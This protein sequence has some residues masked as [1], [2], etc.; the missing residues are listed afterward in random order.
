MTTVGTIPASGHEPERIDPGVAEVPLAA[1]ADRMSVRGGER[2]AFKVSTG[3][4]GGEIEAR[5]FRSISADPNPDGPGIVEQACDDR[6]APRRFAG[7][8]Q[9][10]IAGS[11]AL[12]DAPLELGDDRIVAI[13]VL[14]WPTLRRDSPQCLVALG[15]FSLALDAEGRFACR[16]GGTSVALPE[17][18]ALR[19]WARLRAVLD[20]GA[21]GVPGSLS[22]SAFPVTGDV[23]DAHVSGLLPA[24]GGSG[25]EVG[26]DGSV[27]PGRDESEDIGSLGGTVLVAASARG[28][29]PADTGIGTGAG[30]RVDADAGR[31]GAR[32]PGEHFNGKLEAPTVLSGTD[33]AS[34][35]VRLRWD[36][37]RATSST[38]VEDTGPDGRHGYL[39][40]LPARAMTGAS[41]D[42]SETCWRHAPAHYGAIHFHE[43]DLVDAR[44]E[45]DFGFDVPIDMPSG[46]YVMR[47][48]QGEHEDAVPFWVCAPL[49]KPT[50]SLCVL[51]S[52][53]TYAVYG[54]HARP[55]WEPDWQERVRDWNAWPHNPA[56]YSA[57]GLSTY[58][59]HAD[60]SGICHASHRRPLFNLRPG[61]LTFSEPGHEGSGLRHFQ[62][63]S[64]LIAWL[65][66]Q[67]IDHDIITDRELHDEGVACLAP[68]RAVTTGTHPEYHTRETLDAL[69]DYRDGGG[70]LAYLGGNG[71]YWRVALHPEDAATIE[72]RRAESGIRAW[73]AEPGEYWQAFDGA[74]G[75]LWRRNGRPPQALV[76]IGFS[77]QGRMHG[78][79]YRRATHDPAFDWV[80]AGIESDVIGGFGLCGGGAAGFELDRAD[81]RLGTPEDAVVLARSE[82]H[83]EDFVLVPEEM[84]TH[85]TTVPGESAEALLRADMIWHENPR[86]GA[87]FSVGSITFCGALP[88]NGFDN[89]V[90]RLLGNV[91]GRMLSDEASSEAS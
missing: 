36:F 69:A 22:L 88:C 34:L 60:G 6:F 16:L 63:D 73:A 15:S 4:P 18:A 24:S 51:V 12:S 53:F 28:A 85:L 30:G 56:E 82:G 65:H 70:H 67:G 44:W 25:G 40:N 23:P 35:A 74:Y 3:A 32:H 81:V 86:G 43:D 39:V 37:A 89:D 2:I 49:G 21:D 55:D 11:A 1:Y 83:G 87:V 5:L 10:L 80:F 31:H 91:L 33:E 19:R 52:T 71:F 79:H 42:G 14:A 76:G 8:H 72:I 68:Y 45:D 27:E 78:S 13:E 75:G 26:S 17:R 9:P 57:Y 20:R 47:L 46:V 62:A 61:Y 50:A 59:D 66:A 64:H 90:S 41:W 54:N 58:N 38:R 84:L 48:A 29:H 7:R 77:A